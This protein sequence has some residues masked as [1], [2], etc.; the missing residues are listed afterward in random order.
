MY[1]I[2]FIMLLLKIPLSF[3]QNMFTNKNQNH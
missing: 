3:I 1:F 2:F